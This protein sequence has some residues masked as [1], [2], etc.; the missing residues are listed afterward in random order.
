MVV[1]QQLI[2]A[3]EML[4]LLQ[5]WTAAFKATS[6][7]LVFQDE[8]DKTRSYFTDLLPILIKVSHIWPVLIQK[9]R[10]RGLWHVLHSEIDIHTTGLLLFV[11]LNLISAPPYE[12]GSWGG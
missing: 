6:S 9:I 5:V 4:L 3:S 1:F 7:F 11:T 12:L 8:D 2:N 10:G